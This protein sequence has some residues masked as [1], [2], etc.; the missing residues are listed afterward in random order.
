[1][2]R[3]FKGEQDWISKQRE[4]DKEGSRYPKIPNKSVELF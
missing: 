2:G 3:H 4:D 1:M